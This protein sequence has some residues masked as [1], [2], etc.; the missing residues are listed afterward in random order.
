MEITAAVLRAPGAAF[1]IET[2][3]LDDPRPG[4][5]VVE[6]AGTGVCHTDLAFKAG[7]WPFPLPAVLGHEGAGRVFAVGKGVTSVRIGDHVVMSNA[8]C[9]ACAACLS[10][11]PAECPQAASLNMSGCRPDGSN[12]LHDRSGDV[13]GNFVGQSSFATHAISQDR[14]VVKVPDD[15]P[16][17]LIGSF[18]CGVQTGAGAVL[19]VLQPR[20]GS[21]VVIVGLGAVGLAAV[22]AAATS[23]CARVIAADIN[24]GR[25]D[26]AK[27]FGATDVVDASQGSLPELVRE[28][29]P[30]GTDGAVE[31]SGSPAALRAAFASTHGSGTTVLVGAAPPGT[32]Y[33][34]EATSILSGRALVGATMGRSNPR[35]FIPQLV[36]MFRRGLLPMDAIVR[37]YPLAEIERALADATGGDVIKPV[38]IP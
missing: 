21:T 17:H 38:V 22:A 7:V 32:E 10:G 8:S 25:F 29:V 11:M 6:I 23:G 18:G 19:N 20:P 28:L 12:A 4:E 9:A 33:T 27:A 24:S 26:A 35:V 13:H 3:T 36:D 37:T 14:F 15:V 34:L 1:D 5:V 30:T 16:L 31:A 2:L